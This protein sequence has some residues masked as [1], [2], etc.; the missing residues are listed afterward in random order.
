[1]VPAM[2]M[3]TGCFWYRPH[4]MLKN[5][6]QPGSSSHMRISCPI[7]PCSLATLSGVKYGDWTKESRISSEALKLSEQLKK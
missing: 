5:T 6:R 3:R 2:S 1:M 4:S 7:M